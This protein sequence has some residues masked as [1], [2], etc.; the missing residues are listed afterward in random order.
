MMNRL[1]CLLL[2]GVVSTL[3]EGVTYELKENDT[4]LALVRTHATFFVDYEINDSKRQST[5]QFP[6]TENNVKVT[7]GYTDNNTIEMFIT[8]GPVKPTATSENAVW[9]LVF[10][11]NEAEG[12]VSVEESTLLVPVTRDYTFEKNAKDLNKGSYLVNFTDVALWEA[13]PEGYSYK[14]RSS[15]KYEGQNVNHTDLK[16]ILQLT[17]TQIQAFPPI[18]EDFKDSNVKEC[19]DDA[20]PEKAEKG[21]WNVTEQG[22]NTSCILLESEMT[23]QIKYKMN[24]DK[25]SDWTDIPVPGNSATV[26]SKSSCDVSEPTFVLNVMEGLVLTFH[27]TNETKFGATKDHFNL[28]KVNFDAKFSSFEHKFPNATPGIQPF[29]NKVTENGT[30]AITNFAEATVGH[31]VI[32]VSE[33]IKTVAKNFK[34]QMKD[35]KV[36]A[37]ADSNT[38]LDAEPCETDKKTSDIVPIIVGACLAALVVIVL[39]AYLIGR[40]RAK[41]HGY[42]SV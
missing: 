17:K 19:A 25:E 15:E 5:A 27:F 23:L 24:D 26:D 20:F 11:K 10:K 39:I 41:R 9:T 12:S 28:Y 33:Q 32:C 18:K 38:F 42:S 29:G 2:I 13:V 8:F 3:T 1:F 21:S 31:S 34:I 7:G 37:F 14:C 40:A 6:A 30:G 35:T 16:A 36:Q 4:T 22:K